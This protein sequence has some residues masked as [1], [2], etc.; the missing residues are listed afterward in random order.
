M[1]PADDPEFL[2]VAEFAQHLRVHQSVVRHHITRRVITAINVGSAKRPR[3][4]IR[5]DQLGVIA[6]KLAV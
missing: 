2:T 3:L 6:E 5:R 1:I 4:R